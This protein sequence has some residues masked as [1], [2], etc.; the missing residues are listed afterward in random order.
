M[1]P[2]IRSLLFPIYGKKLQDHASV[3]DANER[4]PVEGMGACRLFFMNHDWPEARD[5]NMSAYNATEARMVV[6]FFDYLVLNGHPSSKIT[7]LTFYHGQRKRIW[8]GLVHH[9]RLRGCT[10]RV[11]TVDSYQG[12]ENDIVILSLVRNNFE[13]TMGFVANVNRV[14][15]ALSRAKR[16][17]YMFGNSAMLADNNGLWRKIIMRLWGRPPRNGGPPT[18]RRIGNRLPIVCSNH[19]KEIY[20][21]TPE[22]WEELYGGCDEKCEAVLPCGHPCR[23]TCHP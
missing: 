17:F 1:V 5:D 7:I 20:M 13:G 14:C 10:F 18:Q 8:G 3:T 22:D 23:L 19:G 12:E 11:V 2:E 15:V 9:Q 4:P 6:N 21:E 16:G